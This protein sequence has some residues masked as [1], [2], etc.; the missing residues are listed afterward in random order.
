MPSVA[1]ILPYELI[2]LSTLR[3]GKISTYL[4]NATRTKIAITATTI[5]KSYTVILQI[6]IVFKVCRLLCTESF[7]FNLY[8][9]NKKM[10]HNRELGRRTRDKT[11]RRPKPPTDAPP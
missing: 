8:K 1:A 5:D 6:I 4:A 3:L 9:V 2:K 7:H 11:S 10:L